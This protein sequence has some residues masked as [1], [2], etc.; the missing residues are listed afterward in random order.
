ML[1]S[2]L[3]VGGGIA[4]MSLAI[5]LSKR[6][7]VAEIVE[8][9]PK[10]KVYG[11]GITITGPTLRALKRVGV[12][13]KVLAVGAGW[14][15][16]Y[17]FTKAGDLITELKT[18]PLEDGIPATGGVLRPELH[19]IL[20]ETTLEAG[21]NVRLGTT[22]ETL[23]QR[24][25]GVD[26]VFSDG[27]TGTYD[28]VVGADGIYSKVRSLILPNAPK[29]KFTGQACWRIVA[30]RPEGFDRSHFYMSHDGKCG[31]NPVSPTHMYMFLL[32][33]VPSNPWRE[34]ET[35]PQILYDL[36]EGYGG[37]VPGIRTTVRDNPT[38]NY[39]P[40]EGMIVPKPWYKGDVVLIGDT[41]H[42]TTPHLASGAGMAVEDAVVLDEELGRHDNPRDAFEAY[43]NRR[44]NRCELIVSSSLRLGEIEMTQ[45]DAKEHTQLMQTAITALREPV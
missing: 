23:T 16:G 5:L 45:G 44:F 3:I 28:M 15:D 34:P 11:A 12:L 27:R 17:V 30:E 22:I 37:I 33:H 24:E 7:I 1:K 40:L 6:G 4:G 18:F 41:V 43:Q 26:V 21:V 42:G 39:R 9:D 19:R 10:W 2:V 20:S 14:S 32:E 29:P 13:D 38:I 36:M 25:R 8:V 31:F 35:L